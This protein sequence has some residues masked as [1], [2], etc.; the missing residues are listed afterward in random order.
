MACGVIGLL[1]A[2]TKILRNRKIA[3]MAG[4]YAAY[5]T[6]ATGAGALGAHYIG[7]MLD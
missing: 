2:Q 6:L 5:G 1:T 4:R 7:H 3:S